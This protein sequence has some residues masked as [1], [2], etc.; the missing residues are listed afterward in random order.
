VEGYDGYQLREGT[1]YSIRLFSALKMTIWPL[2]TPI[3]VAL[4]LN[5]QDL[6]LARPQRNPRGSTTTDPKEVSRGTQAYIQR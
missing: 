6:A 4:R 5:N 1:V 2:E 3:R